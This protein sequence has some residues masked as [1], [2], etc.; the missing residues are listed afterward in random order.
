MDGID[1]WRNERL[2]MFRSD[3]ERYTKAIEENAGN[4]RAVTMLEQWIASAERGI[5][6]IEANR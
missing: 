3:I 4:E 1:V 5:A 2:A 6:A